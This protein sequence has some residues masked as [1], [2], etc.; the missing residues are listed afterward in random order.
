MSIPLLIQ[1]KISKIE[2][3]KSKIG[4]EK[5]KSILKQENLEQKNKPKK[6]SL[7][8]PKK[9]IDEAHNLVLRNAS[10]SQYFEEI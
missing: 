4:K 6:K 8:K 10:T 9:E 1:Y 7:S 5:K 2:E 3:N